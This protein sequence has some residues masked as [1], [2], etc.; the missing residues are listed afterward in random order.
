MRGAGR[1]PQGVW[2]VPLFVAVA[3]N[4]RRSGLALD[5]EERESA[6][7]LPRSPVSCTA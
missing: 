2:T 5:R 3:E 1:A 4:R 7:H 6:S